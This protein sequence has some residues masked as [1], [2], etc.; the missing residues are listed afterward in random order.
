[1]TAALITILTIAG[2]WYFLTNYKSDAVR[3]DQLQKK[4]F[5][6]QDSAM[7]SLSESE[8]L[9][10]AERKEKLANVTLAIWKKNLENLNEMETLNMSTPM[11]AEQQEIKKYVQLRIEETELLIKAVDAPPGTYDN[12]IKEVR[13]KINENVKRSN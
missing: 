10:G 5:V 3:V 9:I 12:E 6:L 8:N 1:M 7:S 13:E 4:F 11:R 2:T